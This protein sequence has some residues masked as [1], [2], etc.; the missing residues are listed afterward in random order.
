[1]DPAASIKLRRPAERNEQNELGQE[2]NEK[3]R[4]DK[5]R[6]KICNG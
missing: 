5:G 2:A 3:R 6:S 1:M 4:M